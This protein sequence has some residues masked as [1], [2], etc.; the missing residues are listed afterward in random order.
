MDFI[1]QCDIPIKLCNHNYAHKIILRDETAYGFISSIKR[2]MCNK[3]HSENTLTH[4]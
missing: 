2:S 4:L 1:K 3:A